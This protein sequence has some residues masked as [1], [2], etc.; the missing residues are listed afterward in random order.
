MVFNVSGW[1]KRVGTTINPNV[2]DGISKIFAFYFIFFS[3]FFFFFFN[4]FSKFRFNSLPLEF[5]F[6]F[7]FFK[8]IFINQFYY[9]I[10]LF[11]F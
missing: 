11:Y 5:S 9:F 6:S 8:K 3:T 7:L 10:L 2:A 1:G 4:F